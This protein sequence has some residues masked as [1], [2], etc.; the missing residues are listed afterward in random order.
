MNKASIFDEHNKPQYLRALN[1][2]L[3]KHPAFKAGMRFVDIGLAQG[4]LILQV[5]PLGITKDA[6]AMKAFDDMAK[7]LTISGNTLAFEIVEATPPL[8]PLRLRH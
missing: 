5:L 8:P 4:I 2:A 7:V 1:E 6:R 3:E